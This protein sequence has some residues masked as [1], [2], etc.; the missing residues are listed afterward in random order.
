LKFNSILAN[1]KMD[2]KK[3]VQISYGQNRIEN[4]KKNN[5]TITF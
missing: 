3:Y 4:E 5:E 1:K 2:N